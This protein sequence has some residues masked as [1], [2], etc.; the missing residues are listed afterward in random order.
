MIV[1]N[2]LERIWKVVDMVHS[3]GFVWRGCE[4]LQKISV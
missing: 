2:E 1:N 3:V 4:E